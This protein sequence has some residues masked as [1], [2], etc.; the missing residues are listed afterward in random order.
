MSIKRGTRNAERGKET[1]RSCL[2]RVPRS[3]LCVPRSA[4]RVWRNLYTWRAYGAAES[5]VWQKVLTDPLKSE[6][7]GEME[8]AE[9]F[10]TSGI[11]IDAIINA[12]RPD[13]QLVTQPESDGIT[14]VL[15]AGVVKRG[16]DVAGIKEDGAV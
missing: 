11:R 8:R 9:V 1:F 15:D 13:R 2:F 4:F 12:E 7:E 6:T 16:N 3:A 10:A 5:N 14:H